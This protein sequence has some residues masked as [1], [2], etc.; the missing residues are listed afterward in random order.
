MYY[1]LAHQYIAAGLDGAYGACVPSGVQDT[2][3]LAA[4]WLAANTQAACSGAGSC[5]QQKDWAA[6]LALYNTGNYPGGPSH[7]A[8]E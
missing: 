6:T 5:G 4:A 1:I 2:L 3:D 8:S 7:C